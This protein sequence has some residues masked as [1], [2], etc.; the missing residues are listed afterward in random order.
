MNPKEKAE[1]LALKFCT[2][3]DSVKPNKRSI[4]Q[5]LKCC[6]ELLTQCWEYRE[7]DLEE[8]YEY[9]TE[10]KEELLKM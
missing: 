8:S 10:V 2:S 9:W 5:A 1:E 7:I 3:L 4:N 6:E